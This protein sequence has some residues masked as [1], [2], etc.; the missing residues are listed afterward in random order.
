MVG[1][2]G[3]YVRVWKNRQLVYCWGGTELRIQASRCGQ[4]VEG[5]IHLLACSKYRGSRPIN[6]NFLVATLGDSTTT[7]P[8]TKIVLQRHVFSFG[9]SLVLS[10]RWNLPLVQPTNS[11]V[12]KTEIFQGTKGSCIYASASQHGSS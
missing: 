3:L 4:R 10:F 2:F 7:S 11:F 6:R 5:I 8:T 12:A 1:L 9:L